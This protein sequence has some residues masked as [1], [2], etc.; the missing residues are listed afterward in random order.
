MK[1]APDLSVILR[2]TRLVLEIQ[3]INGYSAPTWQKKSQK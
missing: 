3:D 1:I 2:W